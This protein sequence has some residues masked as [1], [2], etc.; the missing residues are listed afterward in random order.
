VASTPSPSSNPPTTSQTRGE[1]SGPAESAAA[2][3]CEGR[4]RP[5]GSDVHDLA[6][7]DL[8]AGTGRRQ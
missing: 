5:A 6:V 2:S 4:P 7:Q 8:A 1:A 3:D